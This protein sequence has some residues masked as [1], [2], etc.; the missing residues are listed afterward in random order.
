MIRIILVSVAALALTACGGGG[1]GGGGGDSGGGG[2]PVNNPPVANAGPSQEVDTGTLV[3]LDGSASSDP[4]GDT[5][6]FQWTLTSMPGGS[7]SS[8]SGST[9][10]FP[11]FTADAEGS[12]VARLIVN[13]G[14]TNSTP[15]T[16]TVTAVAPPAAGLTWTKNNW[17]QA[18]WQ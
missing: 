12:Y 7:S 11:T 9:S 17:D 18:N 3:T 14:T 15:A 13:D 5:L 8:L 1:G 16:V 6:S 4:D 2:T 10:A